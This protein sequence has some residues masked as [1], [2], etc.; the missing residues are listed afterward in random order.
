VLVANVEQG[1]PAA[2]RGLRTGDIIVGV[3]RSKVNNLRELQQAAG[4]QSLLL[5]IRRGNAQLI[6]PIR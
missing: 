4:G 2:Q 6:L 5:N 1:S 3:N